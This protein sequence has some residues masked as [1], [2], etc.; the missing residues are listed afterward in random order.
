MAC[1]APAA[2]A[3]NATAPVQIPAL[4]VTATT[5]PSLV[6]PTTEEARRLIDQTP[7]GV[8]LVPD[9]VFKDGPA[10]TIRDILGWVP[11]VITQIRRGTDARVSIR[12]YAGLRFTW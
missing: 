2:L 4:D 9:T 5:P 7:G 10:F 6:V 8:E 11:G 12:G 3:Q 1:F